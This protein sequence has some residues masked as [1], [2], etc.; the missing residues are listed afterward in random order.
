MKAVRVLEYGGQLVFTDVPTPTGS[1]VGAA[2]I[3]AT[4]CA[5]AAVARPNTHTKTVTARHSAFAIRLRFLRVSAAER[6][7]T[8]ATN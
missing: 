5:Q 8:Y 2:A 3:D 4:V 7:R 6:R 1:E